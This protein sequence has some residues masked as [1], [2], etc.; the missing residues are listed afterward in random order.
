[1]PSS[2]ASRIT[3]A[4][5]FYITKFNLVGAIVCTVGIVSF[6]L[7]KQWA[8]LQALKNRK[9]ERTELITAPPP[10]VTSM[11]AQQRSNWSELQRQQSLK[12]QLED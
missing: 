4:G 3:L 9:A 2:L 11:T 5:I 12:R 8:D 1:M 10:D 7:F 6:V